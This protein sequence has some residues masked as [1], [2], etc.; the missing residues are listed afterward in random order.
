MLKQKTLVFISSEPIT[1]SAL[2]LLFQKSAN[3][4]CAEFSIFDHA[5][6][7]AKGNRTSVILID[8]EFPQIDAAIT[9]KRIRSADIRLPVVFLKKSTSRPANVLIDVSDKSPYSVITKPFR[10]VQLSAYIQSIITR[11]EQ[12]TDS[13]LR[14]GGISFHPSQKTLTDN[15]RKVISLTDK[16]SDI[17]E[18]LL[19]SN[20]YKATRELLLKQ[21][22]GYS[23]EADTHTID[24]HVYKL[25]QKIETDPKNPEILVSKNGGFQLHAPKE[26]PRTTNKS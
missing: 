24:T 2:A 23:P 7:Y 1:R 18:F 8:A 13:I 22:W 15:N 17:L 3:F 5:I 21:V 12:S 11:F 9:F 16:E 6:A 26:L 20:E 10:F 4:R 25:R 19:S 14:L